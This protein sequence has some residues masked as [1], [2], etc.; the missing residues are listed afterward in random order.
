VLNILYILLK[1]YKNKCNPKDIKVIIGTANTYDSGM[2]STVNELIMNGID[3]NNISI[4]TSCPTFG[5]DSYGHVGEYGDSFVTY[6]NK[7]LAN[8]SVQLMNEALT[9]Y[10]DQQAVAKPSILRFF[11][12]PHE[13][14]GP[15]YLNQFTKLVNND[16]KLPLISD[17]IMDYL[18]NSNGSMKPHSLKALFIQKINDTLFKPN[19]IFLNDGVIKNLKK[20]LEKV[21][22]CLK[23]YESLFQ[24][25]ANANEINL[26]ELSEN[27][28]RKN[29]PKVD[30][31]G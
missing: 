17:R 30:R 3:P 19:G 10:I 26:G 29:Y 12:R 8:I 1:K 18:V 28:R 31:L 15:E 9:K 20:N 14:K 23:Q 11:K 13:V 25:K 6:A 5:I 21:S 7:A 16:S 22:Y 27:V 2:E 4:H 24:Q